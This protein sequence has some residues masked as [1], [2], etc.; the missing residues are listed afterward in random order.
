L[1]RALASYVRS[2]LSG[3]SPVDR[4]LNGKRDALSEQARKGLEIFRG[5][6]NCIACHIGPNFTDDRFHNTGV[7]WRGGKLRDLGR[8]VVTGKVAD[9]GA[10]KTPTLREVAQTAPYMH[11][12][13][14]ASLEQVVEFYNRG[15]NPNS[16]QDPEVRP[17]KL[18]ADEKR[19][20]VAFLESLSGTVREGTSRALACSNCNLWEIADLKTRARSY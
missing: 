14:L 12:G 1:A 5:K 17:L 13:S 3:A 18:T 4:Y 6:G 10:F 15:G 9:Q 11:D 8:F 19:A 16:W 7:A 20:L 2:I